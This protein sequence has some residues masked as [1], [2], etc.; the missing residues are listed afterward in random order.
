MSVLAALMLAAS[1]VTGCSDKD[2]DTDSSSVSDKAKTGNKKTK[3]KDKDKN[4]DEEKTTE[5]KEEQ[6]EIVIGDGSYTLMVYMVGSNLESANGCATADLEEMVGSG[7]DP[8]KVNLVVYAGGA[9]TWK[10]EMPVGKNNYLLYTEDAD[11]FEVVKSEKKAK[12]CDTDTFADF[13]TYTYEN[14]PA[15]HYALICWDHGGGSLYGFGNDELYPN[16]Y[17]MY[18]TDMREALEDSPFGKKNKLDWVGFDACLMG[19]IETAYAFSDHAD[20]LVASEETEPGTG[21]DYSFLSAMNKTNDAETITKGIVDAYY[22]FYKGKEGKYYSPQYSLSVLDLSKMS[23]VN[24]AMDD[25]FEEMGKSLAKGKKKSI[26]SAR[27]STISFGTNSGVELDLIDLGDLCDHLSS[28]YSDET[29]A[30]SEALDDFIVYSKTN[31]NKATGV[32][33]Y[34][35]YNNKELFVDWGGSELYSEIAN[36]S[37]CL[38]FILASAANWSTKSKITPLEGFNKTGSGTGSKLTVTLSDDELDTYSR[39][40]YT[41]LAKDNWISN[42]NDSDAYYP[43]LAEVPIE[44]DDDGTFNITASPDL[45]VATSGGPDSGHAVP[46]CVR[47]TD[48]GASDPTYA[49]LF[50]NISAEYRLGC[51]AIGSTVFLRDKD[52]ELQIT[53]ISYTGAN[54]ELS[55]FVGRQTVDVTYYNTLRDHHLQY[56]YFPTYGDDG[57][58]LPYTEWQVS[59]A[60]GYSYV[61]IDDTFSFEK[62]NLSDPFFN[63]LELVCQVIV[64]DQDGNISCSEILD[65]EKPADDKVHTYSTANGTITFHEREDGTLSLYQY[66]GSDKDVEIPSAVDGITVTRLGNYSFYGTQVE[67]VTIPDTVTAAGIQVFYGTSLL[68]SL[69]LSK[70]LKNISYGMFGYSGITSVTIPDSVNTIS[71]FAFENSEVTSIS[72]PASVTYIQPGAFAGME[73]L[74]S[75]AVDSG[76]KNYTSVDGVLFNKD[77]TVLIACTGAGRTS[78]TVPGTVEEIADYAFVGSTVLDFM[79]K[80]TGLSSITFNEGLKRIGNFAFVECLLFTEIDLPDSLEY[81]GCF[82]FNDYFMNTPTTTKVHIGKNL[83]V[84]RKGAFDGLDVSEYEV[85]SANRYFKVTDGELTDI[86]GVETIGKS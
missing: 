11:D 64:E 33:M 77:K 76:N 1:A 52:G 37:E 15:D 25:L 75:L 83:S 35:P 41:I 53:D 36:S 69:T 44:P 65:V 39:A 56:T 2:K 82:A 62:R 31:I 73:K 48:N 30:L 16:E 13:L 57:K 29:D 58:V 23:G 55:G 79:D 40:Y 7:L 80:S 22:D 63:D 4:K 47:R 28:Y 49:T 85:D 32:S 5:P 68:K 70:N 66:E 84:I 9:K 42:N 18:L 24:D 71:A 20:Y 74:T 8:D 17:P 14:Y 72:V 10:C 27:K 86:N 59:D 38:D 3:T 6:E 46:W 61:P 19:T 51:D 21:W 12:M 60:I 54:D 43:L 81:I 34:Y 78:Y 26:N 67:N 50:T 45:I